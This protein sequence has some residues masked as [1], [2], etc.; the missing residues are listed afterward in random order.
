M[1]LLDIP[2]DPVQV[3]GVAGLVLLAVVVLILAATLIVGFV[4]VLKLLQRRKANA[5]RIDSG[6]AA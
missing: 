4:F 2:S 5:T 6:E 1:F 3:G